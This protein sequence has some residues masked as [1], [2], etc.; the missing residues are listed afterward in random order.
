[1]FIVF[2]PKQKFI[3]VF[4]QDISVSTDLFKDQHRAIPI[5]HEAKPLIYTV[6]QGLEK[7]MDASRKTSFNITYRDV[8]T[9]MCNPFCDSKS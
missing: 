6:A 7:M 2:L 9:T 8:M 3:I 5:I 1:M 4:M